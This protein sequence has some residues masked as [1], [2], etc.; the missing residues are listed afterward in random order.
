MT[1][2]IP[3]LIGSKRVCILGFGSE[4][5]STFKLLK[6]L[7]PASQL[8][9]AD[10]RTEVQQQS[11]LKDFQGIVVAGED[12]LEKAADCDLIIKSPGIPLRDLSMI[13]S[14]K[15]TSQTELFLQ[16]YRQ[17]VIGIT[18]TKGKSTTT[19]LIYHILRQQIQDVIL[20]GNIG[21]PPF[22]ILQ[23]ITPS[24][25]IVYELSS[26]QLENIKVSPHIALLLNLY[27][28]HLDHYNGRDD[29]FR[30]K[31]QIAMH[32]N[33]GDFFL[34]NA[35]D[36]ESLRMMQPLLL[37]GQKVMIHHEKGNAPCCYST[38]KTLVYCGNSETASVFDK[39]INTALPGN[40]NI[41]NLMFAISACKIAGITDQHI[42]EGITTFQALA[43]R[44]QYAG[45]FQQIDFYNDSIATIPE[46]TIAAVKAIPRVD[47]LLLG[48]FDRGL[49]YEKL[50]EFLLQSEVRNF[51]FLGEA[52]RRMKAL[53]TSRAPERAGYYEASSL[54]DAMVHAKKMT[55]PGKACLLS[56]AAASY[57]M[58]KNF[59]E[60]GLLFMKLA[61]E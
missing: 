6:S 3:D 54:E 50:I 47:T 9:I 5:Q 61:A 1:T 57:D 29:Y 32:Q 25:I 56:P 60:R 17:Q 35:E 59:E 38:D 2:F 11:L 48:G 21:I 51:I 49:A 15:I 8:M 23:Q 55:A 46:A 31:L 36:P 4:G 53:M 28:E 42:A 30:A 22:D 26:H 40:H 58:F 52:G 33:E 14:E 34:F 18:G 27:E 7:L 20:V 41:L 37:K 12:Y 39:K 19:T 24:S 13:P 45:C 44:L 43:H 16:R 10:R